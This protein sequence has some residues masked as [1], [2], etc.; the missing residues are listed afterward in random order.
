MHQN[1][2]LKDKY[3]VAADLSSDVNDANVLV[4]I[5]TDRQQNM[6]EYEILK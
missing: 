6:A 3:F 5:N 4:K 1:D 2:C